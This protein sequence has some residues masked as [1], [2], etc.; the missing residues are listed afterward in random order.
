[1]KYY[2]GAFYEGEWK[3]GFL[4]GEGVYTDEAKNVYEGSFQNGLFH[5][6]GVMKYIN[7]DVYDGEW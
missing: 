1:M 5:G 7:G 3:G 6:M 2:S 4:D